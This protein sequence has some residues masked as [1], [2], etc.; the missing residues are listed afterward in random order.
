MG[1]GEGS[2]DT[3]AGPSSSFDRLG[4][5]AILAVAVLFR[6][7]EI[8]SLDIWVDEANAILTAR[9]PLPVLLAKLKL[10]SSPPFFYLLLHGWIVVFGDGAAALRGLSVLAGVAIF[11]PMFDLIARVRFKAAATVVA[12]AVAAVGI[13]DVIEVDAIDIILAYH[14]K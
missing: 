6:L 3:Q 4:L 10:D 13:A 12:E 5:L 8:D 1:E 11:G 7:Y 2:V 14:L 9:E